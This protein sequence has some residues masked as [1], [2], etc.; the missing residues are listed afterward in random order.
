MIRLK[1]ASVVKVGI[2]AIAVSVL[3]SPASAK[4]T[5][6][7]GAKAQTMVKEQR[8]VQ[9][10]PTQRSRNSNATMPGGGMYRAPGAGADA[11]ASRSIDSYTNY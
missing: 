9:R 3:A 6:A 8:H 4:D 5:M 2:A 7:K 11:P 1:S 10:H